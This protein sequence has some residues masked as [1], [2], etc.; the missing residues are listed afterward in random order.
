MPLSAT[1][2]L[3]L[4][5]QHVTPSGPAMTLDEVESMALLNNPDIHV[6]ARQLAVLE[7]RVPAAG[8]LDDPFCHVSRMGCSPQPALE[9]QR[10]AE[11][12]HVGADV[13]WAWEARAAHRHRS[14]RM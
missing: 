4:Q 11:H 10:R 2:A 3:L 5:H 14:T 1:N 13:P 8:A 12:V 6:A 7:A 9:L